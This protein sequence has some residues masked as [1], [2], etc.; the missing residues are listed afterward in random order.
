LAQTIGGTA[1]LTAAAFA[2]SQIC[3][4]RPGALP[5]TLETAAA[6]LADDARTIGEIE[7]C[8]MRRLQAGLVTAA[9]QRPRTS[10][11]RGLGTGNPADTHH[12]EHGGAVQPRHSE[13]PT[14][15]YGACPRPWKVGTQNKHSPWHRTSHRPIDRL[16]ADALSTSSESAEPIAIR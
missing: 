15:L 2:R 8:G 13:K 4:S 10:L 6:K 3:L 9:M 12:T 5:A 16:M 11:R 7:L 14:S 1:A